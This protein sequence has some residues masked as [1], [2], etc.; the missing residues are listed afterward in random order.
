MF[1]KDS[2]AIDKAVIILF[3]LHIFL[4]PVYLWDSG[5]PQISAF[6]LGASFLLYIIS[7]SAVLRFDYRDK[8][9]IISSLILL[10]WIFL[11]NFVWWIF[12]EDNDLIYK[13]LFY[14]YNIMLVI[15]FFA[16]LRRYGFLLLR[17]L[18]ISIYLSVIFQFLY[19]FLVTGASNRNQ[20]TFNNPNQLGYFLILTTAIVIYLNKYLDR[21]MIETVTFLIISL[22]L[23]LTTLSNGAIVAWFFIVMPFTIKQF[24]NK[25]KAILII[26]VLA[27][28][29]IIVQRFQILESDVFVNVGLRLGKTEEKLEDASEIR[30][31][32]R[33]VKYPQYWIVGSGEGAFYRFGHIR[34]FHSTIGNIQTSYGLIGS[35]LLFNIFFHSLRR[36]FWEK[37]ILF[38]GILLY[39]F[40]HNGIRTSLF[41]LILCVFFI[42]IEEL[43]GY[44]EIDI[45]KVG[46]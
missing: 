12:L 9:I 41:W 32:Y 7:T 42:D 28:A 19:F 6:I 36:N 46:E 1:E 45:K 31:Y 22:F 10:A 40:A 39:G 30:G 24:K 13:N 20:G 38:F 21:S 29:F 16:Y 44:N 4:T 43:V 5:T 35:L 26:L 25:K 2:K 33:L 37:F 23:V 18:Y 8:K 15:I 17:I 27:T 14:I 3:G 11:V 34:E